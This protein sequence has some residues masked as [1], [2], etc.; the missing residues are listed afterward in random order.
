MCIHRCNRTGISRS[1]LPSLSRHQPCREQG[2]QPKEAELLEA[3]LRELARAM[4]IAL[5]A[6]DD[7]GE[8]LE[9]AQALGGI[10]DTVDL[11]EATACLNTWRC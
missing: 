6:L 8:L 2:L 9:Q 5:D 11:V 7:V 4:P 3:A 1:T 10:R